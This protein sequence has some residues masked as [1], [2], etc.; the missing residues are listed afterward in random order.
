MDD[1]TSRAI[2]SLGEDRQSSATALLP[3]AITLLRDARRQGDTSLREVGR[4]L[5]L[6]QPCMGSIW[7]A[8]ATAL[9]DPGNPAA[10]DDFAARASRAPTAIGRLASGWLTLRA[11]DA[12]AGLRLVTCSSSGTVR[13][14]LRALAARGP[15]RV[16]CAEGRPRYEGRSL[17][18]GL[19]QD[20]LAVELFTDAGLSTV[21]ARADGVIVGADAIATDWFIN[22]CG[23]GALAAAATA[24]N[25]P[26]IIVA[27]RDKFMTP[28]L[29]ARLRLVDGSAGE[30]W[31][32]APAGVSVRNPYFERV[33][34]DLVSQVITE[35]GI[36]APEL[37][38]DACA[39]G[40]RARGEAEVLR[41]VPKSGSL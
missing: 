35:A 6:A 31:Q 41:L 11:P 14:S 19:A 25:V 30:V 22:K 26:V 2:A 36:L 38:P 4:A 7:N 10:L 17:A 13:A 16:A 24:A 8:V 39:S 29:A 34:V 1:R 32:E 23:T 28:A 33:P 15:V 5:C 12:A 18:S 37:V 27:G 20:G 21:V 40:R 9:A 3:S